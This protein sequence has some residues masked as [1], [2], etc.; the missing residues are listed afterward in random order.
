MHLLNY[1]RQRVHYVNKNVNKMFNDQRIACEGPTDDSLKEGA[2]LRSSSVK[3]QLDVF[4]L[5][6]GTGQDF[7]DAHALIDSGCTH[8]CID[9]EF[10]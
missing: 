1:N 4:I 5:L 9:E 6:K 3:W 10:V 7:V 2:L 8:L